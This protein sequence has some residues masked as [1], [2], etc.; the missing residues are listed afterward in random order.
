MD[1]I[2][3][4]RLILRHMPL[5]FLEA[6]LE[7][8]TSSIQDILG[9][10]IPPDWF[11]AETFISLRCN[12]YKQTPAYHPWGPRAIILKSQYQ[13]IGMIGFHTT[14]NPEYL[15]KYVLSGIEFGYEI[16]PEYRQQGYASEAIKALMDWAR[17]VDSIKHFVLSISPE[18]SA[19]LAIAKKFG[20]VKVGEHIDEE[21]GLEY[22]FVNM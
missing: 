7:P 1:D 9:V 14:P 17:Q 19:S 18:N 2:H 15:K 5:E 21:D 10:K 22:V 4:E 11:Q 20:F 8:N 13:M 12:D 3:T 6:S 16:F